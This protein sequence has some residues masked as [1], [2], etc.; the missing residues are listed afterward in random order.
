M[1]DQTL[2]SVDSADR[3]VT[4]D[5]EA[6]MTV[7]LLTA[8]PVISSHQA[9]SIAEA[10]ALP[11]YEDLS[12]YRIELWQDDDGWHV[13]YRIKKPRCAGGGP[14]YVIHAETGKIL[15]KKYYQ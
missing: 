1:S 9:L 14:H 3:P 8:R 11:V 13:E 15:S 6:F 2:A 5:E 12:I 4:H 10:D 7:A